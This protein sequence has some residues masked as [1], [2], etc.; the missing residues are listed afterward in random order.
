MFKCFHNLLIKRCKISCIIKLNPMKTFNPKAFKDR[1]RGHKEAVISLFSPL[2]PEGHMLY[3]VS[4]EGA[5][6]GKTLI[7]SGWDLAKR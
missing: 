7:T 6:R 3:S 1:L 5:A 4:R 2:G